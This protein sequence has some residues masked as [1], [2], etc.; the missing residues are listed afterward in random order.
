[1]IALFC[2]FILGTWYWITMGKPMCL[3][4]RVG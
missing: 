3:P 4:L 2:L 1:M